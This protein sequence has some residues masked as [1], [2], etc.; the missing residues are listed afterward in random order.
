MECNVQ[1][2]YSSLTSCVDNIYGHPVD[3]LIKAYDVTI[4]RYRKLHTQK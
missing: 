1:M 4:Q 3:R 2:T